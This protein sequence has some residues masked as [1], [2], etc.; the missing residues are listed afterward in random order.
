M[1]L[2]NDNSS[3]EIVEVNIVNPSNA[4]NTELLSYQ[5]NNSLVYRTRINDKWLL[6]KRI[7]PEFREHPAYINS[8]E[9]EFNLG[10]NLDH[11]HIVKY[12]NRGTDADGLYLIAEYIDGLSLPNLIQQNP[13]GIKDYKLIEKIILQLSDALNYLHKQQIFHLDLK[14]ENII[15][16]HKGNN[17]K[18]I[19]FGLSCSDSF[20][21]IPSGT[22]KYSSPEQINNIKSV[23]AGSDIYSLGIIFLELITG[24]TDLSA[25]KNI[26]KVYKKIISK[27]VEQ[28]QNNRFE[29]TEEIIVL[30]NKKS[31]IKTITIIGILV[32][33]MFNIF[34]GIRYFNTEQPILNN[35]YLT[36]NKKTLDSVVKNIQ[37][38]L[39]EKLPIKDSVFCCTIAD[40]IYNNFV[41]GVK[42]FDNSKSNKNRKIALTELQAKCVQNSNDSVESYLSK[43]DKNSIIYNKLMQLY[44]TQSNNSVTKINNYIFNK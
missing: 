18:I 15:I 19:D 9:K 32:L 10:F 29:S 1:N 33:L 13:S 38:N 44:T 5:S 35:K 30:L 6:L 4:S 36:D 40:N 8:L 28:I 21:S 25:L 41:E 34:I 3:F 11:P 20:I 37:V 2:Y 42:T 12:L 23:D 31:R 39:A 16:T 22:K 7:K 43:F 26:R 24:T 27:C 14:P 17:V